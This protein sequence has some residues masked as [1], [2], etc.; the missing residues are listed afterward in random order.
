MLENILG[1]SVGI[2]LTDLGA[3]AAL[4]TVI[5]QV[6]KQILPKKFPTKVLTIIVSLILSL[7]AA[8][9]CFDAILKA[10]GIGILT[11][12]IVAFVSMNGFDSLKEIWN[13][14][15]FDKNKVDGEG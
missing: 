3:L 9:I 2:S 6:L 8:L 5:V 11:G 4:T 13:R 15:T 7:A 10:V 12:F 14:F 1:L